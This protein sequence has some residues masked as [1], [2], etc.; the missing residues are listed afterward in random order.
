[1]Q[2]R[3]MAPVVGLVLLVTVVL[4]LVLVLRGRGAVA[5][6]VR[7]EQLGV[8]RAGA[9]G[10][11][12]YVDVVADEME[13][14]ARANA[15]RSG[16][17]AAQRL[18]KTEAGASSVFAGLHLF[19]KGGNLVTTTGIRSKRVALVREDHCFDKIL[20]GSAF[21]LGAAHDVGSETP[22]A[23]AMTPVVDNLGETRSILVAGVKL[24][25]GVVA[26][27]V[28]GVHA[29]RRGFAFLVDGEGNLV[30]TGS[31]ESGSAVADYS[32]LRPVRE[33]RE[34]RRGSVDYR[35]GR[36]RVVASFYPVPSTDWVF[37]VQRPARE[38][39]GGTA[40]MVLVLV[41]F[42]VVGVL[43]AV[44]VAVA[45][46]QTFSRFVFSLA[47]RMDAVARGDLEQRIEAEE[48]RELAP[49]AGAFNRMLETVREG[50]ADRDDSFRE[51]LGTAR[52]HQSLLDS[53]RDFFVVVDA[54]MNVLHLSES[55]ARFCAVSHP[56]GARLSALGPSWGQQRLIDAVRGVV[57]EG[58][59]RV[60]DS[61]P[62]SHAR[63]EPSLLRLHVQPLTA[64]ETGHREGAVVS[65][66]E[67]T[68]EAKQFREQA[69][70]GRFYRSLTEESPV[71][72]VLLD[73]EKKVEWWNPAAVELLDLKGNPAGAAFAEL[74]DPRS[75]SLF[76]ENFMRTMRD[77]DKLPAW[78]MEVP[79]GESEYLLEVQMTRVVI[80]GGR[81]RVAM[82]MRKLPH[83]R[84]LE[85]EAYE[86]K[87]VLEK[88]L[89]YFRGM[90]EG[91]GAAVAVVDRRGAMVAVNNHFEGLVRNTRQILMGKDFI[92]QFRDG[93]P[94]VAPQAVVE[95]GAPAEGEAVLG[96]GPE[97][98]QVL[99]HAEPLR[100]E[101]G[102]VDGAVY[103]VREIGKARQEREQRLYQARTS[104]VRDT[105]R[106][107]VE[108]IEPS[109]SSLQ[110]ALH[111][112]GL[113]VF[114]AENRRIWQQAATSLRLVMNSLN[115][116]R[117]FT[118]EPEPA[119]EVCSVG[120]LL[121]EVVRAAAG[122]GMVA[123]GVSVERE[124]D[125]ELP[126]VRA[127]AEQIKMVAWQ[128]LLNALQ[129]VGEEGEV[130]VRAVARDIDG[131][132]SVLVEVW[133]GGEKVAEKEIARVFDPFRGTRRGGMGLGLALCR[134]VVQ[135]HGG[136]I[137]LE[138]EDDF[139]RVSFYLP[140]KKN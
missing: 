134:R 116:L 114:S 72:V 117:L 42:V 101:D 102:G 70:S 19:G 48:N 126:E 13:R 75:R 100:G 63:G 127:D 65:G 34:G 129:A 112:L 31:E 25:A 64:S 69:H 54:Q 122:M 50:L 55:A 78:E 26:D 29:G 84:V 120:G 33:A 38:V 99:L 92:G 130:L 62:F 61:M 106:H 56:V 135:S 79:G 23:Y 57:I 17:A 5:E 60:I 11:G 40:G 59:E 51:L 68:K 89:R 107:I 128:L 14:I 49:I 37:V 28:S 67:I 1:M 21:C 3:F 121:D 140:A 111:E 47:G 53:I 115:N 86:G 90:L 46:S 136:R 41:V 52:F 18:L 71:A 125:E 30:W 15:V 110:E 95:T 93:P 104:A 118:S 39:A 43:G 88:K 20:G 4:G 131:V 109:V 119:Y 12:A 58:G 113:N 85:R 24:G 81:S 74:I 22:V 80:S 82:H 73:E 103:L 138:R 91:I 6:R 44:G 96:A 87:P 108:R 7:E 83:R 133:N 123:P 124:Y 139:T 35:Y 137:G 36:V 9:Y 8:A 98:L 2:L 94:H 76:G 10:V 97:E 66:M 105:A 45:L 16:A 32:S 27:V 132:P 77:G